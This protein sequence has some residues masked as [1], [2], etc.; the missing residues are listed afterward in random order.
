MS[1]NTK[2]FY[3]YI[4]RNPLRSNRPFYIGKGTGGRAYSH[5][6]ESDNTSNPRKSYTIKRIKDQ[7]LVPLIEIFKDDL[8]EDQAYDLENQLIK[9]YGRYKID[10]GGILDNL[11]IGVKPPKINELPNY[12]EII[13]KKSLSAKKAGI[14]PPSH[15]GRKRSVEWC[16]KHSDFWREKPKSAEQRAKISKTLKGNIP[17]NKG[18]KGA[19]V[20]TQESNKKRSEALKKYHA[21][22]RKTYEK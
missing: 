16:K 19:V 20:Q 21:E 8:T 22:R 3:V 10:E 1:N 15:K 7:N 14:I 6:N 2:I 18:L 11:C 5:L 13:Q 17:W 9:K 4:L 12:T